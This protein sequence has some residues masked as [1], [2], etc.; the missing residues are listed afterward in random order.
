M[1]SVEQ[2]ALRRIGWRIVPF[3]CLLYFIAFIDRVK[4]ATVVKQG[5]PTFNPRS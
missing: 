3:I 5:R 4:A 1:P 2:R